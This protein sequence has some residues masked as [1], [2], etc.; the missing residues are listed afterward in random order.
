MTNLELKQT[1][2]RALRLRYGF[3]PATLKEIVLLE[4]ND[5]GKQ[6][7]LFF[8]VHDRKYDLLALKS[9]NE[10]VLDRLSVVEARC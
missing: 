5:N 8:E 10:V 7:R 1:A 9:N 6:L 2:K 4:S 3:A